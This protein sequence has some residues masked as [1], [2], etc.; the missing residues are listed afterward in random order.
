MKLQRELS[1]IETKKKT[2]LELKEKLGSK[3]N[4]L[5]QKK[6]DFEKHKIFSHFL[7]AVVNDHS[8]EN[9]GFDGI[10]E[11]Q[12]RFKSL[13][14]ENK[15]LQTKKRDINEQMEEAR[16]LEK[17]RLNDLKETLYNKQREMQ[18]I[19]GT[20]EEISAKNSRLEQDFEKEI[21]SKN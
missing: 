21:N 6:L 17:R 18:A 2:I 9:E 14:S 20:L 7:D 16:A 15:N 8:G 12:S 1:E 11:L 10:E 5:E 3:E 13:K 19:Q 4:E